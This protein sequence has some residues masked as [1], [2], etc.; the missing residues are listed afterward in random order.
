MSPVQKR[1]LKH[2]PKQRCEHPPN[3]WGK[4]RIH[5]V[6]W[7]TFA[8]LTVSTATLYLP[9]DR[10]DM[11]KRRDLCFAC[12]Q[13][14]KSLNVCVWDV[15]NGAVLRTFSCDG[16]HSGSQLSCNAA[17]LCLLKEGHLLCAPKN[18]PYIYV[19]NLTKVRSRS[20]I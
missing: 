9:R 1:R 17:A 20:G 11:E 8:L 16:G 3:W 14:Q 13:S 19:W 2:V 5:V 10:W 18:L 6:V 7:L 15:Q 12:T 4:N